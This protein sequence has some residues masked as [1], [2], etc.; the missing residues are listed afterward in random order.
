MNITTFN[1][2]HIVRVFTK[3][4]PDILNAS[5]PIGNIKRYESI[6]RIGNRMGVGVPRKHY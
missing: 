4:T 1:L 3:L 2:S 6:K 5:G